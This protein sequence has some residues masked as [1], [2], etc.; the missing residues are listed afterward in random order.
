MDDHLLLGGA[1]ALSSTALTAAVASV[2]PK[3]QAT[4]IEQAAWS[5]LGTDTF[6]ASWQLFS[7]VLGVMNAALFYLTY[8]WLKEWLASVE[9]TV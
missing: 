2:A 6:A 4:L 9:V 3:V 8:I 1:V 7:I 5:W